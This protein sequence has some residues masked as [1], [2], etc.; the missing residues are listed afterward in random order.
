MTPGI[1]FPGGGRTWPD[2]RRSN[3]DGVNDVYRKSSGRSS[4]GVP[5]GVRSAAWSQ[6]S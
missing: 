1:G 2:A 6:A 4:M 3:R 5:W